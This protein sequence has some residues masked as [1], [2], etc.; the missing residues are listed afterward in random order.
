MILFN[1]IFIAP[2]G[3]IF[4]RQK[5]LI[6]VTGKQ[7]GWLEGNALYFFLEG[8]R[9]KKNVKFLT[10]DRSL[11]VDHPELKEHLLLHPSFLSYWILLRAEYFVVDH[12]HWSLKFPLYFFLSIRAKRVHLWHGLTFKP[13][14]LGEIHGKF[15]RFKARAFRRIIRYD[16][17][18]S[19]SKYW[20]EH[21]YKKYF[22]YKEI[23]NFGYP[24]ND[25]LFRDPD[26]LDMTKV[27][28]VKFAN[29]KE[30]KEN[31]FQIIIYAP[32]YR[33]KDRSD[34]FSNGNLD[35][36][37]LN[38]F[39]KVNKLIIVLKFHPRNNNAYA[40][41]SNIINYNKN[42]DV[43][44]VMSLS[45]LLITDYSSIYID[46]LIMDRPVV[47]FNYDYEEYLLENRE[48]QSNFLETIPGAIALNQIELQEEIIKHLV[49]N[50]DSFAKQRSELKDLS[51]EFL[52]GESSKRIYDHLEE[53]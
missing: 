6:I 5:G 39:L 48:L 53:A 46:Y 29:L 44:P 26:A 45:S 28:K 14:E 16:I 8:I 33:D 50:E 38:S 51:Y 41:M 11:I 2:I 19:T 9:L 4:P 27:D 40:D 23:F 15:S 36:D 30:A 12:S 31:G 13:V 10:R 34:A 32:T 35:F 47:F 52:D 25:V 3:F 20:T 17:M 1:W 49:K 18:I 22:L 7:E 37:L 43:Y 24:R 42:F 21:L